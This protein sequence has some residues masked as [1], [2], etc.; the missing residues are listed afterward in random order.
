MQRAILTALVLGLLAGCAEQA[1]RENARLSLA[2]ELAKCDCVSNTL[3]FFDSRPVQW[4]ADG[5]AACPEGY[6]LRRLSEPPKQ[7]I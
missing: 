2:C 4:N 5:S 7:P 1:E 6:H 3:T